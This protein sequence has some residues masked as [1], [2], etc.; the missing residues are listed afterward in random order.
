LA[1]RLLLGGGSGLRCRGLQVQARCQPLLAPRGFA[2]ARG[3]ILG[4][5]C[6]KLVGNGLLAHLLRLL[7]VHGLHQH[8]LVLK[9]VTLNLHVQVVVKVLI[10]LLRVAV[11]LQE[12]AQD[13]QAPDPHH[14]YRKASLA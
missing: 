4:A 11:L 12:T 10:N 3:L 9:D 14:L 8:A 2:L 5:A 1:N 13:A 7:L 6:L